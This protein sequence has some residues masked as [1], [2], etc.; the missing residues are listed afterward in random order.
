V[1]D[2]ELIT[3]AELAEIRRLWVIEKHEIEDSLPRIYESVLG[4]PYPGGRVD[5][6]L[7]L[8]AE[9]M[10]ILHEICGSDDLHFQLTRELLDVERQH[11]SMA[12]RAGLFKALEQALRRGFYENAED[13]EQRAL[14]RR[15]ALDDLR[16][17]AAEAELPLIQSAQPVGEATRGRTV[18]R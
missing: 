10:A 6:N 14:S 16:G 2:I 4:A 3:L 18:A 17:A 15:S 9:E 12:R 11:R 1:R 8:G 7:V 5:D 13:A